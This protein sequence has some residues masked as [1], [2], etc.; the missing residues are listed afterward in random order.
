[1]PEYTLKN[2]HD[3]DRVYKAGER[4]NGRLVTLIL[5]KKTLSNKLGI[6]IGKKY[7]TAVERNRAKR[8]IREAYRG[9]V[10]KLTMPAEI[11]IIPRQSLKMSGTANV[12]ADIKEIIDRT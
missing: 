9:I 2:K 11:I 1:M 3:F 12:R 8:V 10:G 7:G 4:H 5:S 6:S